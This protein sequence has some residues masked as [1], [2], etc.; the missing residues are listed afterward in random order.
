MG[1]LYCPTHLHESCYP[2]F[3]VTESINLSRVYAS[4]HLTYKACAATILDVW[5]GLKVSR[6][7]V[8][9]PKA[10]VSA[11]IHCCLSHCSNYSH[12][13]VILRIMTVTY[14][15]T[16]N[17]VSFLQQTVVILA[18]QAA[19]LACSSLAQALVPENIHCVPLNESYID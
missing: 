7:F 17:C 11:S 16:N 10:Q 13:K 4:N 1:S 15:T 3:L 18:V 5:Y 19:T 6:D 8:L 14:F 2:S 12:Q 9:D